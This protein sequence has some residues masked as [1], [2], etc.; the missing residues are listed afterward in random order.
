MIIIQFIFSIPLLCNILIKKHSLYN[1]PRVQYI[2]STDFYPIKSLHK[3]ENEDGTFH[4]ISYDIMDNNEFSIIKTDKYSTQCLE[5]YFIK[6]GE[7]CP[8]TEIIFDN[9]ASNIYNG[10]IQI[11]NNEYFYYTN[12]NKIGKLYKS[13]NY[14]D[15]EEN[16]EDSFS[17]VEI[18]KI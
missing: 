18:D 2:Q 1:A 16:K 14:S 12:E 7:V 11:S 3:I 17:N 4:N 15:F 6:N 13:F 5:N 8:I 10:Y 9:K